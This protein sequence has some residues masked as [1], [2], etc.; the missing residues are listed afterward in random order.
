MFNP[1]LIAYFIMLGLFVLGVFAVLFHLNVYRFNGKVSL[2]VS[3][4][5]LV[6]V[7]ILLALNIVIAIK[8]PWSELTIVF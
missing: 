8:V 3:S 4:L 6:G 5:F 1:F 7:F 2:L